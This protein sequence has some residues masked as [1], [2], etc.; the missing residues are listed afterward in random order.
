MQASLPDSSTR[1]PFVIG[2][3][4]GT[5]SGKTSVCAS[6]I[7]QLKQ[8]VVVVSQ[9]SFYKPLSGAE[10]EAA[11]RSE[12]NFDIPNAFDYDLLRKTLV[13]L[14]SFQPVEIPSYDY[15][16]HCRG[17]PIITQAAQIILVEG[18][19]VFHDS[20]VR[21][22]MDLK[23]FVEADPDIRLARRVMRDT[24]ERGRD[25]GGVLKQ[26][27]GFVKPAFDKYIEPTK[28]YADIVI[29]NSRHTENTVA[30]DLIVQH[31][32]SKLSGLPITDT[33]SK[34]GNPGLSIDIA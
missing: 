34:I 29:P 26:Y 28:K 14:R 6:I 1:R 2:V 19:L 23:V 13:K 24:S 10:L 4:G 12:Y 8:H 21:D 9:D 31:I 25:L 18:I 32:A 22:L 20:S 5:A 15:A 27:E 30:I 7:N 16:A 17:E 11:H 33:Q 3:C